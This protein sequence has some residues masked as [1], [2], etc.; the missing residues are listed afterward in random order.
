VLEIAYE[1]GFNSK[2]AFYEAFKRETD[3]T[4]TRFR[5][6]TEEKTNTAT[7]GI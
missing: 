6:V 3:L 1:V 5:K 7:A 2:T 4:P